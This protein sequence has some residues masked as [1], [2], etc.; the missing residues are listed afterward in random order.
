MKTQIGL[1]VLSI[2]QVFDTLGLI[3]GLICLLAIAGITTW[4]DW[5][6]GVFKKNHLEVYSIADAGYIMFGRVGRDV[7]GTT[8]CLCKSSMVRTVI[9][10][11]I[12]Y[13]AGSSLPALQCLARRSVSMLSPCMG[14][15]LLSSLQLLLPSDLVWEACAL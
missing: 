1:G 7:L 13:K 6:I 5:V 8:Y 11:L 2:P 9:C 3:P 14:H 15:V 12:C 4:S 10:W